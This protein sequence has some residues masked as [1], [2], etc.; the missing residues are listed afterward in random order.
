[1][2]VTI[3]DPNSNIHRTLTMIVNSNMLHVV[4]IVNRHR[5][6]PHY[7]NMSVQ[8]TAMFHGCNNDNFRMKM[9]DIFLIFAQNI[10][11]GYTLEPP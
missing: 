1:M 9:F 3:F 4:P 11:C 6:D 8:N 10:D 7:A 2:L 5:I